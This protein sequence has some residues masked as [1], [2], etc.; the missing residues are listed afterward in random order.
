M[1]GRMGILRCTNQSYNW[2]H[3]EDDSR[4]A[5]LDALPLLVLNINIVTPER[6]PGSQGMDE[7]LLSHIRPREAVVRIY[8]RFQDTSVATRK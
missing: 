1:I 7:Y 5:N 8:S 3:F 2:D 4:I 6:V